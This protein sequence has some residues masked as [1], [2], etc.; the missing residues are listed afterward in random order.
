M[1][2]IDTHCHMD[3]KQFAPDREAVLENA[4]AMGMAGMIVPAIT[5]DSNRSLRCEPLLRRADVWF[6]VGV[7][8]NHI[9]PE[10]TGQMLERYLDDR[11]VA[12]GETGLDYF[13][14]R[15]LAAQELQRKMFRIQIDLALK[16]N[17]PL[18]LHV[19]DAWEDALAV[20]QSYGCAFSGVAHCFAGTWQQAEKFME[21]GFALGIGGTV[22]RDL[23]NLAETVVKMPSEMLLL[24]TDA[25]YLAP[26]G[27]KGRNTPEN[28]PVIAERIA[29]LRGVSVGEIMATTTENAGRIFRLK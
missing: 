28:I 8:P 3:H 26:V 18:I 15:D 25:P 7:H 17:L 10:L 5:L 6:A 29:N 20:L 14:T 1:N 2:W 16:H 24:E 22:T 13:R 21:L 9:E 11:V 27:C 4:R 23:P 12:I 19:R